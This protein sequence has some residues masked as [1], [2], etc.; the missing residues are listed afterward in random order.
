MPRHRRASAAGAMQRFAAY[1]HATKC[2]SSR[3]AVA[4]RA[5]PSLLYIFCAGAGAET[6]GRIKVILTS[7]SICRYRY[8]CMRNFRRRSG[9]H[10]HQRSPPCA[11]GTRPHLPRV[12]PTS[13]PRLLAPGHCRVRTSVARLRVR[14]GRR[15]SY[16]GQRRHRR[17]VPAADVCVERFGIVKR[18]RAD[19]T[20]ST[21]HRT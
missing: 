19:H 7:Y 6:S 16:R 10:L 9:P 1:N 15:G 21:P 11:P 4:S 5:Q 20:R 14:D 3:G 17:G 2:A 8:S 18:L 12:Q 13:P